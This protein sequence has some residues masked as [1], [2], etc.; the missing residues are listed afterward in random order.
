M[1]G[2]AWLVVWCLL[3]GSSS[4]MIPQGSWRSSLVTRCELR[5][6]DLGLLDFDVSITAILIR[7]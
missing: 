3:V 4:L 7:T 2:W 5:V 1:A 6:R